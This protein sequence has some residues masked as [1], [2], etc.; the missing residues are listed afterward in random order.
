MHRAASASSSAATR[1]TSAGRPVRCP[2]AADRATPGAPGTIA[3][4]AAV[5]SDARPDAEPPHPGP[6]TPPT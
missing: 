3:A 6:P 1:I 4:R 5:S 2:V